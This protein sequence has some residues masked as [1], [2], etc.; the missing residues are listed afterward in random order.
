[1]ILIIINIVLCILINSFIACYLYPK[2]HIKVFTIW[3]FLMPVCVPI[4]YNLFSYGCISLN[5]ADL[6]VAIATTILYGAMFFYLV[7]RMKMVDAKNELTKKTRNKFF[8]I[9]LTIYILYFFFLSLYL[10][11]F[12]GAIILHWMPNFKIEYVFK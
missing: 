4:V 6:S 11:P 9:S 7:R 10:F 12:T 1:M 3:F 2:H 8:I 5:S